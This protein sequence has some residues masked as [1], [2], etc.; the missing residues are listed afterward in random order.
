MAGRNRRHASYPSPAK[1]SP[2]EHGKKRFILYLGFTQKVDVVSLTVNID[3]R[4][5]GG[6]DGS[7]AYCQGRV[8]ISDAERDYGRPAM[9]ASLRL[10][11]VFSQLPD[12]DL[13]ETPTMLPLSAAQTH[14]GIAG[15]ADGTRL[16]D[17][18][19]PSSLA[20]RVDLVVVVGGP[21]ESRVSST[22][23]KCR[24]NKRCTLVPVSHR[25]SHDGGHGAHQ[26]RSRGSC[27]NR[28]LPSTRELSGCCYGAAP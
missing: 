17:E 28:P 1:H 19:H 26:M 6:S 15:V 24:S 14:M 16:A 8:W 7:K 4:V 25:G 23:T 18:E 9:G 13:L 20:G 10:A 3:R 5:Q 22:M 2:K 27:T 12:Q 11:P 21:K